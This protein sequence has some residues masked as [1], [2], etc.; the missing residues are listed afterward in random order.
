MVE[1]KKI[2][3][4]PNPPPPKKKI[5]GEKGGKGTGKKEGKEGI[6]RGGRGQKYWIL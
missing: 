4:A 1:E 6:L 5:K 2:S 3:K